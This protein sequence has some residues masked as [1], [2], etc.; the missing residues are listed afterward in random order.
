V[1]TDFR[2]VMGEIVQKRLAN[3]RL[4]E[5]FPNYSQFNTRSVVRG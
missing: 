5:V 4:S 2:D 1:K 3:D